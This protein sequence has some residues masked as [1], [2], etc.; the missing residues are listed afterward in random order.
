M[1]RGFCVLVESLSEEVAVAVADVLELAD[2]DVERAGE[3]VWCFPTHE[4]DPHRF[5]RHVAR[6]IDEGEAIGA[7]GGEPYLLWWD[8]ES[9]LYVNDR[10]DPLDDVWPEPALAPDEIMWSVR[11]RLDEVMK[12]RR[13][14]R[15]LARLRRPLLGE[16]LTSLELGARDEADARAIAAAALHVRGVGDATPVRIGRFRRWRIRQRLAGNYASGFDGSFS[17][18][19]GFDGGGGSS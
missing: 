11:I 18:V 5:R 16:D 10:G 3:R 4:G 1:Q 2:L 14:R 6:L 13:T 19:A 9:R 12:H 17:D 15:G 8:E 7:A